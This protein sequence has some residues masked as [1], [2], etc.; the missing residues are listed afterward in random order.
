MTDSQ[1]EREV[2]QGGASPAVERFS[3]WAERVWKSRREQEPQKKE[4]QSAL[5]GGA[6]ERE[7]HMQSAGVA[8]P[9]QRIMKFV[10]EGQTLFGLLPGLL[11]ETERLRAKVEA[12]EQ[13][14]E[15]LRQQNAGL[16]KEQ[17]EVIAAF[18]GLMGEMLQ[19]MNEMMQR[20]RDVEG[21]HHPETTRF[22]PTGVAG[23]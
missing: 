13:E 8:D 3:D 4:R 22:A 18:G 14:C 16:R 15:Q 19:P 6:G 11:D 10:E 1:R 23:R 21:K 20:V 7:I 12:M 17:E 5:P 2:T 9:R